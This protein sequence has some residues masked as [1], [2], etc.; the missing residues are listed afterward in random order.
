MRVNREL[1][2]TVKIKDSEKIDKDLPPPTIYIYSGV[3]TIQDR[4]LEWPNF[5]LSIRNPL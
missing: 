5:M 1:E 3:Y 2:L 4:L